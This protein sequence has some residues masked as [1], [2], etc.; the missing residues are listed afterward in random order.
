MIRCYFHIRNGRRFDDV[1]GLELSDQ[2]AARSEALGFARDLVRL[3]PKRRD[4]SKWR[5][6]V[7]DDRGEPLLVLRVCEAL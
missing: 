6:H 4:W 5:I 2:D 7:T 3:Y 1:D